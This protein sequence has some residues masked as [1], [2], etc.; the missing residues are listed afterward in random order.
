MQDEPARRVLL[1]GSTGYL[2]SAMRRTLRARG[3][4]TVSVSRGV[5]PSAAPGDVHLRGDILDRPF[6]EQAV[7][8]AAPDCVFLVAGATP[9]RVTDPEEMLRVNVMGT[10]TVLNALRA[11]APEATLVI[12]GSGAVYGGGS[13]GPIEESAAYNPAGAYAASKAAQELVAMGTAAAHGLTVVRARVFNT[14]GPGES[15]GTLCSAVARQVAAA[16]LA[17]AEPVIDVGPLHTARDFVD[18]RDVADAC[19]LLGSRGRPGEAYNVCRGRAVPVR[20][21]VAELTG[22]SRVP[23]V[24]RP[25][26]PGAGGAAGVLTQCGAFDKIHEHTG[27]TPRYSLTQSLADLL[28][29]WRARMAAESGTRT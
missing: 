4:H 13:D 26:E 8:M 21:V 22:M 9:A 12:V 20:D 18:G 27:W 17:L 2:G 24:I 1:I 16:E 14:V 10:A 5:D 19:L 7:T 25:R 29:W 15:T 23:V 28:D 11:V 3:E 6:I